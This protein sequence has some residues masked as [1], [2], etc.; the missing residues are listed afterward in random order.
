MDLTPVEKLGQ[1]VRQAS[2]EAA[3]PKA[4]VARAKQAALAGWKRDPVAWRRRIAWVTALAALALVVIVALL[5]AQ[6]TTITYLVGTE[7]TAGTLGAWIAAGDRATPVRFSEGTLMTLEPG[8]RVRVT[9]ADAHGATMLVERGKAHAKVVH[10]GEST[11]WLV[12]AGPFD[13]KVVGTEFDVAWDPTSEVLDIRVTEGKVIVR[14][15]LLDEGR[16][17][18]T[19]EVL[20]VDVHAKK[21]EVRVESAAQDSRERTAVDKPMGESHPPDD[22]PPAPPAENAVAVAPSADSSDKPAL[23]P[24]WRSLAAAGRHREA[25]EAA[26]QLGFENIVAN[27][28]AS[29]L[30]ELA[31]EA[32]FAGSHARARQALLRARELGAGGRSAFLLGKIAADHDHAPAEAVMWFERYLEESPSGGLAEQA[33]GRI[34]EIEQQRGRTVHARK[35][36]E[37]YLQRH[38]GGAYETLARR[39]VQP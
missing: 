26:E 31:D 24:A 9:G 10:V 18:S 39:L 37:L 6:K 23:L 22:N 20:R 36:A 12:H 19:S 17:L 15:P 7:E 38:P 21:S 35:M 8:A 3:A 16:A 29:V 33:L 13:I 5:P 11:S 32:R 4:T 1:E 30:L 28:P 25:M 27:S 14:G 2:D 34:I